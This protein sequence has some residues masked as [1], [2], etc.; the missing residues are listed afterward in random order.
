[1]R[2]APIISAIILH[3]S[4][5]PIPRVRWANKSQEA[6]LCCPLH[7]LHP[8]YPRCNRKCANESCSRPRRRGVVVVAA[9]AA[10]YKHCPINA[11]SSS[12]SNS[13]SKSKKP[14][15]KTKTKTKI[16]Q[17]LNDLA[18]RWLGK[19]QKANCIEDCVMYSKRE[20]EKGREIE[21]FQVA[22]PL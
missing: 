19:N 11:N 10:A 21:R 13:N 22:Q 5:F 3:F 6:A 16:Q 7:P 15:W 18:P 17:A 9:V 1:M 14:N 12:N 8:C 4:K 2:R 20:R